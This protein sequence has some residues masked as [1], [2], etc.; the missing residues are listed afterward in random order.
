ME[1]TLSKA[2][3]IS[4][5]TGLNSGSYANTQADPMEAGKAF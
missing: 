1:S 5:K 3:V 2:I 4:V